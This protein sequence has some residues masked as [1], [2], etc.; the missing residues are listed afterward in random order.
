MMASIEL[1]WHG[2]E[3]TDEWRDRVLKEVNELLE[4]GGL[5]CASDL[6]FHDVWDDHPDERPR[7]IIWG[8]DG[9]SRF[10]VEFLVEA[11]KK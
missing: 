7:I 5:A 2:P 8:E 9:D 4:H 3:P 1:V 6:L 10:H 11:V